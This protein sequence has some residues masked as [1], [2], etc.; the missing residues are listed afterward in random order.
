M[1]KIVILDRDGTLIEHKPYLS[2]PSDVVL[3]PGVKKGMLLLL[4]KNIKI[5]I[6]TNQS[7]IN[8]GFFSL[9]DVQKCN[10]ALIDLLGIGPGSIEEICIAP[11]TPAEKSLFRKPSPNFGKKILQEQDFRKENLYYIGDSICDIM[12]AYNIGC[13]GVGVN[14]GLKDLNKEIADNHKEL[15]MFPVF[16]SFMDAILLILSEQ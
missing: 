11:E 12:T 14:T 3:L 10:D 5:Y 4:E 13:R 15:L 8:R 2:K 1:K 6:H 7:G 9:L 16:D